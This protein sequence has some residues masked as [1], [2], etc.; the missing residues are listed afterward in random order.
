[1]FTFTNSAYRD[2]ILA[3]CLSLSVSLCLS[4]MLY[5]GQVSRDN[6]AQKL[7]CI[8]ARLELRCRA[9]EILAGERARARVCVCLSHCSLARSVLHTGL[10]CP[11]HAVRCSRLPAGLL[12]HDA[13]RHR[14]APLALAPLPLIFSYKS[15]KSLCGTAAGWLIASLAARSSAGGGADSSAAASDGSAGDG[16]VRD[17]AVADE[18][19]A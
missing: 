19:V 3:L 13:A 18:S 16:P 11:R 8:R 15:E 17:T 1:M 14:C 10:R 2:C 12:A 9:R 7:G 6:G 4:V 5:V